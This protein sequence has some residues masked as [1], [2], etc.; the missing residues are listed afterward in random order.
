MR[1]GFTLIE[2]LIVVVTI[3]IL[4]AIAVPKFKATKART[5]RRQDSEP[6][7]VRGTD[8]LIKYEDKENGVV[9]YQVSRPSGYPNLSCVK[10][11]NPF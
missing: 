3:A 11:S 2:L 5:E 8:D 1:K 7:T 10:V 9:C 4:A 6:R